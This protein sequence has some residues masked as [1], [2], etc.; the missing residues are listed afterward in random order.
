MLRRKYWSLGTGELVAAVGFGLL[1]ALFVV[2]RMGDRQDAA[3]LWSALIPLLVVLVQAGVYWLLARNWVERS[4]MPK[5][6]AA[7]YRCFRILDVAVLLAGLVGVVVWIPDRLA[8]ALLVVGVWLFGVVEYVN[9]FAV[10]LAYPW[11]QWFTR[12]WEWRTPRLVQ[13]LDPGRWR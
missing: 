12:V 13:D 5:P 9:Y 6:V 1:A 11:S 2:P 4:P 8:P 3:A 7:V 10:R